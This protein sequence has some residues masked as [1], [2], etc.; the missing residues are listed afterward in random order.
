MLVIDTSA[1]IEWIL[2]S[3]HGRQIASCFAHWS[4]CVV[5]TIVQLEFVK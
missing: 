3:P 1:W 5:A 4:D 2:D